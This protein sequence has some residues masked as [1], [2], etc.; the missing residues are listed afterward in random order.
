MGSCTSKNRKVLQ[1]RKNYLLEELK[2]TKTK[3]SNYLKPEVRMKI[4]N[5]KDSKAP[6]LNLELN[7]LRNRRLLQLN[8]IITE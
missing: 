5:S 3:S 6:K 2:F 4:F 7:E 1:Y 8:N